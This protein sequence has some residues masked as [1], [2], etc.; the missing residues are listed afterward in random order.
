[1]KKHARTQSA[2]S[3]D[4]LSGRGPRD[5]NSVPQTPVRPDEDEYL[6]AI[7]SP[8]SAIKQQKT[9]SAFEKMPGSKGKYNEI[10]PDNNDIIEVNNQGFVKPF[11]TMANK[12]SENNNKYDQNSSL[13]LNSGNI[14]LLLGIDQTDSITQN[15]DVN[16]G[17]SEEWI[18]EFDE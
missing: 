16:L 3:K 14:S 6:I 7:G 2:I 15:S 1:M 13:L 9:T 12:S 10:K 11:R 4:I 18:F 5:I 17:D 8:K